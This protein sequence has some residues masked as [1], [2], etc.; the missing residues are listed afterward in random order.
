MTPRQKRLSFV[1][2]GLAAI[3]VSAYLIFQAL[4]DATAYFRSPTDVVQGKVANANNFRLGGMVEVGSVKRQPDDLT[5]HFVVTD[6][7]NS[8][9]VSYKGILPDLFT[10]GQGVVTQGKMRA[11]GIFAA[12]MVLAKHD[13]KY[14]PP[15]VADALKKGKA[16]SAANP[17]AM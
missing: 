14:M 5:V 4:G 2:V 11:D 17:S 10:E 13:E 16:M 15:E 9:T 12:D 6:L 7:A 8:V 1:L 3:T